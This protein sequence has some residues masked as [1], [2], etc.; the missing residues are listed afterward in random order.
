MDMSRAFLDRWLSA[1]RNLRQL[2]AAAGAPWAP[3][4]LR[5]NPLRYGAR[6]LS[7]GAQGTRGEAGEACR[8]E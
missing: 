1:G 7:Y 6:E 5:R 8:V 4:S 2:F 3:L